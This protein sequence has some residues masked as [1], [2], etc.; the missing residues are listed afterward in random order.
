MTAQKIGVLTFHKCINY[1]SYWQAR[2]LVE[3]LRRLGH[4]A[5][6]LDHHC[7]CV[8]WAEARC[9]FQPTLPV[10]TERRDFRSHSRKARKFISAI[11][12]LP[13]SQRFSLHEPELAGAYDAILVGSDEV[14][15]LSHPWYGGKPI[16]YGVGLK[17]PRLV[18]YAASFGSYSCHW[19]LHDYWA[20]QLRKFD[21]LSV[22]DENSYWLVRGATGREPETVLD[23]CLQFASVAQAAAPATGDPY[24]VVYGHSFPEQLVADARRWSCRSKVKLVSIGYRNDF[25]DEQRI[26]TGPVEFASL[27]AGARA[28]ITSYFHGCVFSLVNGKPFVAVTSD[29]R[30]N[31]LR[32]LV[33]LVGEPDRLI[34]ETTSSTDFEQLLDTAPPPHVAQRLDDYRGRSQAYLDAALS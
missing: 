9:A 13:L 10:R 15:N 5:E 7:G 23:P 12:Q 32:G 16:F 21:S 24:A 30:Q 18:S 28:V 29:Y 25:A 6:L 14:W 17:A 33:E 8:S 34:D 3:G 4:D 11:G 19:G 31:K 26:D 2:C 20:D 27:I 1:G 22:R